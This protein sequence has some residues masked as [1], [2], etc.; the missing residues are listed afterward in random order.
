MT[1]FLVT[2]AV[3]VGSYLSRSLFILAL[4]RRRI[5][6]RVLAA[7]QFVAPAVLGSLVIS[8]L[9]DDEGRVA[10]GLPE[11]A[12][13]VAGSAVAYKTR[14]HILTLVVGMVVYWVSRAV[15]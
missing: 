5:P 6:D 11:A 14:S 13:L 7:L 2:L 10:I 1:A 12:A 15:T 8:V 4:A 9:I 3:G